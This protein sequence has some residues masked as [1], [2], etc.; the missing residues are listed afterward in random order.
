MEAN[1][2]EI[3]ETD[4]QTLWGKEWRRDIGPIYLDPHL[5]IGTLVEVYSN[6]QCG[7]IAFFYVK[8]ENIKI[9]KDNLNIL[10]QCIKRRTDDDVPFIIY[11]DPKYLDE[12]KKWNNGKSS[13]YTQKDFEIL[14]NETT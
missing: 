9:V 1:M 4:K 2:F 13:I 3:V 12:C 11:K 8:P 5:E 6:N 14:I 10:F 7:K